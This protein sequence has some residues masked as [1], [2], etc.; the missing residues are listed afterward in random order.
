[1]RW[2]K[3]L[4][5]SFLVQ[6]GCEL[7]L[8]L[9]IPVPP[10]GE[11]AEP[12]TYTARVQGTVTAAADSS[13]IANARVTAYVYGGGLMPFLLYHHSSGTDDQGHY[14]LS[15]RVDSRASD[16][17]FCANAT[18]F[19][20]S[21]DPTRDDRTGEVR[22]IDFQLE[23]SGR[24]ESLLAVWG[25]SSSDVY[26]VGGIG[27]I[28]H[29]DGTGWSAITSGTSALLCDV[30]GSSSSDIYAVGSEGTILHYDG[31]RWTSRLGTTKWLDGVWGTSS[32]DV[33]AVGQHGTIL[34]YDGTRWT[35]MTSGQVTGEWLR[36][37]WGSLSRDVYAV[38]LT[39]QSYMGGVSVCSGAI[40]HY[41]GAGWSVMRRGTTEAL[42]GVWG[43]SSSDVYAVGYDGTILHYDGTGW[44]AMTSGTTEYLRGVW[45][46]SSSDI[47]AVGLGGTILHYDGTGWSAMTSGTS[48]DLSGVWGTSSSDIFAVG[49]GSTILHYD[50]TSWSAHEE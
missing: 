27:L 1:M 15:F 24:G 38:G 35:T 21:C 40:L 42:H 2:L 26:A 39:C 12:K 37:V 11:P 5:L 29:Y 25:A 33:F 4:A 45:G 47:Y 41:D 3:L 6:T 32:S 19:E 18:G 16:I 20:R 36:G 28:L 43:T 31:T 50:G 7:P 46:T 17:S 23:A 48:E 30:W 8:D 34:H 13:P 9:D 44:S 22:T 10:I 49:S 14:E